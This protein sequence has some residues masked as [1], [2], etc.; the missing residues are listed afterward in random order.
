MKVYI[1]IL[2][3]QSFKLRKRKKP[4]DRQLDLQQRKQNC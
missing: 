3:Q 1:E 4:L 2:K